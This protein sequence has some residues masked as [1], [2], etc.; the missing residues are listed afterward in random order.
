MFYYDPTFSLFYPGDLHIEIL[1][2]K[3][4]FKPDIL[5][6]SKKLPLQQFIQVNTLCSGWGTM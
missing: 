6:F 4:H 2:Q 3:P 5:L 1:L